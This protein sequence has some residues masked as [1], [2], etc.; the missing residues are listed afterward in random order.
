MTISNLCCFQQPSMDPDTISVSPQSVTVDPCPDFDTSSYMETLEH[1][2]LK[3]DSCKACVTES[4]SNNN[5]TLSPSVL[6]I[7]SIVSPTNSELD[8][9]YDHAKEN[10]L[11]LEIK[12]KLVQ[13]QDT[14]VLPPSIA[15]QTKILHAG[16]LDLPSKYYPLVLLVAALTPVK[17]R[18]I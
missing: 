2:H 18:L 14:Q 17:V 13:S 4:Y 9:E 10:E 16:N 8:K 12:D 5:N 1:S 3:H 6:E 15:P 11:H 7:N